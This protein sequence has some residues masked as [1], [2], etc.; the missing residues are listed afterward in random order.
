LN[1]ENKNELEYETFTRD[2]TAE[3]RKALLDSIE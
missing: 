2:M 1:E 3:D